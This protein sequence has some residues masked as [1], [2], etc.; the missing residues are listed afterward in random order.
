METNGPK[1]IRPVSREALMI[2][3][4]RSATLPPQGGPS[5]E[6]GEQSTFGKVL[7]PLPHFSSHAVYLPV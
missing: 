1:Y 2:V 4:A 5:V 7:P 6:I 3:V